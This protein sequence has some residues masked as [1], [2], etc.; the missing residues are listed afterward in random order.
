[1]LENRYEIII[2]APIE[3]VWEI[4]TTLEKYADWNPLLY[5]AQG[6]IKEGETVFIHA[7]TPTKEMKLKCEVTKVEPPYEFSWFFAVIHPFLFRGEHI[8]RIEPVSEG[9]KFADREWFKG[10][11]LPTQAKDLRTNGLSAMIEM[12]KALKVRAEQT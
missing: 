11:L 10:L 9:V 4:L 1:M 3:K 12:A 6:T 8:F 7:K 2:K 5:H